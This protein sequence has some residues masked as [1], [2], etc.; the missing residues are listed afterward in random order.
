M[1]KEIK[2]V[3]IFVVRFVVKN[4]GSQKDKSLVYELT[5]NQ[6]MEVKMGRHGENIRKR[7]DG[8]W[9]ARYMAYDEEKGKKV[10]HSVYGYT[11]EEAKAK[12]DA[13]V[14]ASK[15]I[16]GKTDILDQG[17]QK[18]QDI[19]FEMAAEEWLAIVKMKH[20]PSTYEKYYI[21]YHCYLETALGK[22]ALSQISET[23]VREKVSCKATSDSVG[24]SIYC[25]LNRI[26]QHAAEKYAIMLPDIKRPS[27]E[28]YREAVEVF[29][30]AEQARLLSAVYQKMDCFK[31]AVLLCLFTG[32]RLGE[33]CALKWTDIDFENRTLF[34]R[35]TVQRLYVEGGGTKTALV[36]T[37]PKSVRS[38]REIPLQDSIIALLF[39]F[40]NGKEYVFGGDRPLESRTMQNHYKKI[41]EE[42]G[43]PYKN[44]HALRHTFATNCMEGGADVKSLSEMLGHS[45]V[46]ITMN[47]Y[48]H[49]S[50]DTKRR[51]ADNLGDFYAE[52][53]GQ[54]GG[55][56]VY[57]K[58]AV[59]VV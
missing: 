24:K 31:L 13:R 52:I 48:V 50:M 28:V 41:L 19:L 37:A 55:K 56:H 33:L 36:E 49:P 20:K 2:K 32:L 6:R 43:A 58:S 3:N 7:G 1:N 47:Y 42:A 21:I 39:R 29:T 53:H 14:K 9:E 34:V 5:V 27:S 11:Y 16:C 26:L 12:R 51:Y 44:F 35:R 57:R 25:V 59:M 38:K 45:N 18:P 17:C 4:P 40:M 10:Y 22:T 30:R 23:V 54:I 46:Q 8:R 15:N